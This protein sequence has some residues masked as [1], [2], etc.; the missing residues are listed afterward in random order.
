VSLLWGGGN[1]QTHFVFSASYTEEGSVAT[2]A[3]A[4]S[5][6]PVPDTTSCD[7]SGTR[8]SSFTPQG[9]FILGPNFDFASITLNDGALNDGG[10]NI[11]VF[12][13]AN[14]ASGDFHA[15]TAADRFNYN[16]ENFNFLRTPSERVNLYTHVNHAITDEVDL[17]LRASYTNRTSDT[18]GAPEPLCLGSGC[19][20]PINDNFFISKDNPFNPFGVDLSV[21]NGNLEFFGRRP[22]ESGPRLFAQDVDTYFVSA[23][24]EGQF[25][26]GE[27]NY[28]WD[29]TFSY[30][31]NQGFQEKQNSHNAAKLQVAM[32]DPAVCAATPN[33]VPF[34]FFGG[35]GPNG[36][37]SFTQEMLDFVTFTQ[38]DFSEQT[39]Q[40]VAFNISGDIVDLAAGPLAFAAG[41]EYRD[42]EGAFRPDPIAERRETAGIPSGSTA[43]EFDVTEFYAELNIPLLAN[44]G[45]AKYMELNLAARTSDYSTS[46]SEGTYKVGYLWQFNDSVSLRSSISTGLRAPG[47]GELF[48]GAARED[49]TFLDPCA[50]YLGQLGPSKGGRDAPHPANIQANCASLG[51]PAGTAQTNPQ[52]SAISAGNADLQA[53]TSDAFSLGVVFDPEVSWAERLTTS[54]DFYDL[55][56]D[57]AIQ[58]RDPGDLI[59]ACANTGN[60]F[61]CNAIQR[62]P[63]GRINLVDNRLQNIGGIEASGIDLMV[64]YVSNPGDYGQ[65]NARFNATFLDEYVE[66]TANPDGSETTTDRTGTHTDESFER[67]FPELRATSTIGW[68]GNDRWSGS[69]TFRY[70]DSMETASNNK[71]DSVV[72]TDVQFKYVPPIANDD[73]TIT[74]GFN[75]VFD[76]DPPVLDTSLVGMSLV[77]HDV[78][79]T[80]GYLR[81]SYRPE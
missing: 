25:E 45:I 72:F 31:D 42:H 23:G 3:R 20:N 78:P 6:F 69:L 66:R 80:V 13:P 51:V 38:R 22:L 56:I 8:C 77:S 46:G 34:N 29:A 30:G 35:Q 28:Y 17:V 68:Q 61:F 18:R 19:G 41:F 75:N 2:S 33:C 16:G 37:G 59:N 39:Q 76:E 24:L 73:V 57:D 1:E 15:F 12:N 9:R 27:R 26:F 62:A 5:A 65:F 21:A 63:S 52:L 14:P 11:P 70:T 79:G 36:T 64:N 74:L 44:S 49:F 53:E 71:L 7:V 54:V 32:G 48:G 4:R 10:A 55:E 67:A 60:P 58:G 81:F 43:G 40:D 50:D 47:I